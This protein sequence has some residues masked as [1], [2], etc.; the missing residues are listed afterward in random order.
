MTKLARILLNFL[1]TIFFV[2]NKELFI[3]KN[4]LKLLKFVLLIYSYTPF[5]KNNIF[6]KIA[7]SDK[8]EQ[9]SDMYN[10]ISVLISQDKKMNIL[11]I[12]I[13]GHDK[14]FSGGNSILA[15]K[16]MYKNSKIIG[17]DFENKKFLEDS[18]I[19]IFQGDQSKFDDLN[20]IVKQYDNFDIIIDDGSHFVN[21]QFASFEFLFKY[22]NDGGL[23]IIEDIQGSYAKSMNGD[24]E[25]AYEKNLV[26]FFSHYTHCTNSRF[27]IKKLEK[28]F[29][30]YLN[31]NKLFFVENAILIQKN[32][33]NI[34]KKYPEDE[35]Y[36]SLEEMNT[37]K[38]RIK[39][40]SGVIKQNI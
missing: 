35:L 6:F 37:K 11:E 8:F 9:Y 5:K 7:R 30:K 23:Y 4:G 10:L 19:K 28:K 38:K 40:V 29:E 39:D 26:T 13:G 36:L 25:L 31:F 1:A 27:I 12:G 21:H 32:S 22:L 15:L 24:P 18:R 34:S 33:K 2:S 14:E 17:L 16:Y 3:R 20:N